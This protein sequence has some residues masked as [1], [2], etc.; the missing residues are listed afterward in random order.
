VI[1]YGSDSVTQMSELG[2]AGGP[3]V[4]QSLAEGLCG[5]GA[6]LEPDA[7]DGHAVIGCR[8]AHVLHSWSYGYGIF[9]QGLF[10]FHARQILGI[11]ALNGRKD[12]AR[13]LVEEALTGIARV[14]RQ[15]RPICSF[16]VVQPVGSSCLR[17]S[18]IRTNV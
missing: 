1:Q 3:P 16:P 8:L 14:T 10:S 17:G 2:T 11:H 6:A 7:G 4:S 15:T 13:S 18:R 12:G 5:R 9:W